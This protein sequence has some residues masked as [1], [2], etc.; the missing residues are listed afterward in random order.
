MNESEPEMRKEIAKNGTY[1][2]YDSR[3]P[4]S[5]CCALR[6][7]V[8][9]RESHPALMLYLSCVYANNGQLVIRVQYVSVA[10]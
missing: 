3:F 7:G 1:I 2:R 4:H 10:R 8:P 5:V 6:S 9:R